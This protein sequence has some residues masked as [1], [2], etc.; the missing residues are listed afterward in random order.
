MKINVHPCVQLFVLVAISAYVTYLFELRSRLD[1][2]IK[3]DKCE[4]LAMKMM[5]MQPTM[6][7]HAVEILLMGIVSWQMVIVYLIPYGDQ[8]FFQARHEVPFSFAHA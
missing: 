5:G 1:Y 3:R 7:Q 8:R 4:T 6:F 2:I